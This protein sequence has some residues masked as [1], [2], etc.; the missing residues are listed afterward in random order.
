MGIILLVSKLNGEN[1][2]GV[3]GKI[4]PDPGGEYNEFGGVGW[5]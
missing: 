3:Y 1:E 2:K 5:W 4:G